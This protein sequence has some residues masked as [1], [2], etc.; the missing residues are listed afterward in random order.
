MFV[1]ILYGIVAVLVVVTVF[2]TVRLSRAYTLLD[3]MPGLASYG[4]AAGQEDVQLL[5][6]VDYMSSYSQDVNAP[7]M[8]A[9]QNDGKTRIIFVPMPQNAPMSIRAA[10][11]A[12]A[13]ARQNKEFAL[14][15]ELMRNTKPLSEDVVAEIAVRIGLDANKLQDDSKDPELAKD[16]ASI[17]RAAHVLRVEVT[18][19][20][21]ANHRVLLR[22]IINP[23]GLSDFVTLIKEARH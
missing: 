15:E 13:A 6:F 14:H 17:I 16:L 1:R 23:L 7:L 21:I 10:K 12:I 19:T 18:P 3:T 8:Q 20:V 9:A 2:S 5:A 11:L 22:P 4:V